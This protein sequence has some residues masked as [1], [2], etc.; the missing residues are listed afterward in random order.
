MRE[1]PVRGWTWVWPLVATLLWACH[2]R[3]S[4][5]TG[6]LPPGATPVA[7]RSG[8]E[9]YAAECGGC[10][11]SGI[12]GAPKAGDRAAWAPRLTQGLPQLVRHV[13]SGYGSMPQK[14]NCFS[15][16]DV[17]IEAAVTYLVERSR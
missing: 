3:P 5:A 9:I 8:Q 15:C 12:A 16:S 1:A 17:E 10:H 4:G 11:A 7:A 2:D 14:G 13:R 6:S